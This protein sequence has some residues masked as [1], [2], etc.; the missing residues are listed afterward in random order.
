MMRGE[1]AF[2]IPT[3]ATGLEFIFEPDIFGFGQAMFKL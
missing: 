3:D 2:E 1:V